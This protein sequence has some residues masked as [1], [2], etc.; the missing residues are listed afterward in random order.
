MEAQ[1]RIDGLDPDALF[2]DLATDAPALQ[3]Q[4]IPGAR[5]AGEAAGKRTA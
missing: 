3:L 5:L 4:C 1:R 2:V